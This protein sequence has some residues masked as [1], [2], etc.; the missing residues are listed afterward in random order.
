MKIVLFTGIYL[1]VMSP[2]FVR[3]LVI[4]KDPFFPK[5]TATIFTDN[6]YESWDY[7]EEI[8]LPSAELYL[9]QHTFIDL[10]KKI[11]NKIVNG[12]SNVYGLIDKDMLSLPL[13]LYMSISALLFLLIINIKKRDE[14]LFY[15]VMLCLIIGYL[16]PFSFMPILDRRYMIP[17]IFLIAFTCFT[18]FYQFLRLVHRKLLLDSLAIWL[19]HERPFLKI[20][21]FSMPML[22]AF[23]F[24]V[25]CVVTYKVQEDFWTG[26]LKG[27][28][29]KQYSFEDAKL[30]KDPTIS[31]LKEELTKNDVILAPWA[32]ARRLN[33][34]TGLTFIEVPAN[35]KA[36][37]D[38]YAFF[39]KYQ[40]NYSMVDVM[41][42]L[43]KKYLESA[44]MVGNAV[45]YKINLEETV[46]SDTFLQLASLDVDSDESITRS[47]QRGKKEKR[48]F[49]DTL[50]SGFDPDFKGLLKSW[51]VSA[52]KPQVKFSK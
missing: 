10:L 12:L 43:P 15:A 41:G 16:V 21:V 40:I 26:S 42:V 24:L 39:K 22:N 5:A 6:P 46:D 4:F 36:L 45:V 49:I 23:A 31:A 3:N 37:N 35:L 47:I 34:G 7:H 32:Q 38:P 1:L 27:Y 50:H 25:L 33:F 13:W 29:K 28:L 8:P 20:N 17:L 18:G 2:W 48:I 52:D 9:D 19:V 30:A 51:G 11:L 44:E 14:V